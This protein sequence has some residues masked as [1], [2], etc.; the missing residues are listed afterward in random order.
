[1]D[2]RCGTDAYELEAVAVD[3]DKYYDWKNFIR[4]GTINKSKYTFLWNV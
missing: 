2:M 4:Q 1:M 3:V